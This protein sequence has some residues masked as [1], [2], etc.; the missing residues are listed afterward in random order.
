[1]RIS[2]WSSD[3]C[4]SDLH[5][6]GTFN[7]VGGCPPHRLLTFVMLYRSLSQLERQFGRDGK[8]AWYDSA[9]WRAYGPRSGQGTLRSLRLPWPPSDQPEPHT[10]THEPALSAARPP[11]PPQGVKTYPK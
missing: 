7:A 4:S 8:R 10:G 6:L 9:A 11:P 5:Y 2:D 3:V 1:M